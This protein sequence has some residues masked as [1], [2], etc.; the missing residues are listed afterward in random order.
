MESVEEKILY[1]LKEDLGLKINSYDDELDI[2]SLEWVDL[3]MYLEEDF[4]MEIPDKD[5]EKLD[6]V[7]KIIAYVTAETNKLGG[8]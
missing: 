6:T 5:I 4:R 7:N 2:D 3:I 1:I 8:S